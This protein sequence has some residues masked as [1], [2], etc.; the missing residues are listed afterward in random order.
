MG[1]KERDAANKGI[2]D[3]LATAF[4][5]SKNKKIQQFID[6]LIEENGTGH[7]IVIG[8]NQ[9]LN[10]SDAALVNG[11]LLHY[12]DYDDVHSDLRGHAS[13]VIL[14]ALLSHCQHESF[15]FNHFIDS[16]IVGVEVAARIGRT[17]GAQHYED[18][19]HTSSTIGVLAA[20]AA[21]AYF[22][23]LEKEEFANAL[24]IAITEASG[25]R[26]QFGT[27]V[28]PL[29]IGLAAQKAYMAVAYSKRHIF[30]GN[31][32]ML[33]IFYGMFS[34]HKEVPNDIFVEQNQNW[35]IQQPGLWFKLYPC[36]SANYHAIDAIIELQQKYE[37][38]LNDI[39]Q[40]KVIFPNYGDLALKFT[41]PTNGLEGRFSVEFVISKLLKN[42]QLTLNDFLETTID[43]DIQNIMAKIQ[44]FYDDTITAHS[45]AVP[46]GRFTIVEVTTNM[47]QIYRARVDAPKGS[48]NQP[49]STEE[50]IKKLEMYAP[51]HAE[52]IGHLENM[53]NTNEFITYIAMGG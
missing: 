28:K 34:N 3:F 2:I 13:S 9:K 15:K 35:A 12:Y 50:L 38:H 39:A 33:P 10:P 41:Q 14:P 27:D 18:G 37:L 7:Q 11:F 17:I 5:S 8:Y 52:N 44:R 24:G 23:S 47:K 30:E 21:C 19:W 45:K 42:K 48:P 43:Q 32:D 16:Y 40:V 46:V 36:C 51:K 6:A 29:H 26:A 4:A 31:K 49:L 22:L 20:T 53:K 25:F 1:T